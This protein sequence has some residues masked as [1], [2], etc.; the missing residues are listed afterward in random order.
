[1]GRDDYFLSPTS[2]KSFS[3]SRLR[4]FGGHSPKRWYT[5]VDGAGDSLPTLFLFLFLFPHRDRAQVEN[6]RQS[7]ISLRQKKERSTQP[8]SERARRRYSHG[9]ARRSKPRYQQ[10]PAQTAEATPEEYP[11]P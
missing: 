2:S 4:R 6:G 9:F 11:L 8:T 5:H 7:E 3:H 10:L 1:M